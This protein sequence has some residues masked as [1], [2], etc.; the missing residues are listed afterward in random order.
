VHASNSFLPN[1][2]ATLFIIAVRIIFWFSWL[3]INRAQSSTKAAANWQ[4]TWK[5]VQ[6][7]IK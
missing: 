1:G 4:L 5:C 2:N 3:A 6:N 7:S